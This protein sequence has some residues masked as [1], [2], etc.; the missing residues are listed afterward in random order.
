MLKYDLN[1]EDTTEKKSTGRLGLW[2]SVLANKEIFL[3][4]P[5]DKM[6]LGIELLLHALVR[7]CSVYM[8]QMA[9]R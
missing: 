3:F 9:R 5:N 7:A 8:P 6:S 2:A 4:L 1:A